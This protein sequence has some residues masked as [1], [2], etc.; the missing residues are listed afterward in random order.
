[1]RLKSLYIKD[2]KGFNEFDISFSEQFTV[3]I[4]DN[5]TGKTAILDAV[6]VALGTFLLGFSGAGARHII[7][8]EVRISKYILGSTPTIEG[9]FPVIVECTGQLA[10]NEEDMTWKRQ[11][12]SWTGRT[13]WVGAKNIIN[14]ATAL[15]KK[16]RAGSVVNLPIIAYYG[17]GRLWAQKRDKSVDP[18]QSGS[19]IKGYLDCL[20]PYSNEKLFTKWLKKMKYITLED[21]KEPGEL[22]AVK[23]AIISCFSGEKGEENK[24]INIDYVLKADD[25]LITLNDGSMLP[26]RMMSDGYRNTLGMVADIAF[27]MA[28]LNPH[29]EERSS[30]ETSGVVLIDEIDLHL[31]PKWQRKIVADLRRTFPK[32]Q[33]IVTTHSP[34]IVQSLEAGELRVLD[35]DEV[36]VG[37]YSDKSIEDVAENVM[38]IE[39]PQWSERKKKMFGAAEEYY[40]AL[41]E[42]KDASSTELQKLREKLDE[43]SIPFEDNAG[44]S[45]FLR[46]ER[47]LAEFN[48]KDDG[49]AADETS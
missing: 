15:H 4:G 16:V 22:V 11:L 48:L 29:L 43:L 27:R 5:G 26:L 49:E 1:M 42:L 14:F 28:V 7:Q 24:V 41:R 35:E 34:F 44:F 39:L 18:F 13:T 37:D 40:K 38:G 33:F 12:N 45:A 6:S 23:E 25:T 21:G 3:L 20:D 17:T 32:V 9:Q 10:E 47:L 2:F 8:D 31:H 46:Q 36:A 19:R 30:K